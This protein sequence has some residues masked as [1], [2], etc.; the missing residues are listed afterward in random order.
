MIDAIYNLFLFVIPWLIAIISTYW[1][2]RLRKKS[3][4][5]LLNELRRRIEIYETI[6]PLASDEERVVYERVIEVLK[7][8]VESVE[9]NI[10][11]LKLKRVRR[12]LRRLLKW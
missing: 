5:V 11:S 1:Q 6:K 8:I 9:A 2:Y 4:R 3:E 7:S 10:S 12:I